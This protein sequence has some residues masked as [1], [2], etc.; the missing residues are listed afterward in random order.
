LSKKKCNPKRDTIT[1][2]INHAIHIGNSTVEGDEDGKIGFETFEATDTNIR[3][4][5]S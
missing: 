4:L 2:K 5:S 3:L 1:T